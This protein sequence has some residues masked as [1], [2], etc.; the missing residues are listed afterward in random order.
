MF[1]LFPSWRLV[2]EYRNMDNSANPVDITQLQ[3]CWNEIK[4]RGVCNLFGLHWDEIEIR[5]GVKL[6]KRTGQLIGFKDFTI[7][8]ELE[9]DTKFDE[10]SLVEDDSNFP[11]EDENDNTSDDDSEKYASDTD[12][13]SDGN[14]TG[15]RK[16]KVA[17]QIC[18][19]FLTSLEGNFTWPVGSFPVYSV[20]AEKLNKH[21][22]WPLVKA[23]DKVSD[24]K[25]KVVYG[26][27]DGGP[28]NSIFFKKSSKK[29]SMGWSE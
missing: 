7:P 3:N 2:Q 26:V 27:C 10:I 8:S 15:N 1:A 5:S 18:Q 16:T 25:I 14:S 21:M 20:T 17:R 23:L 28:W 9:I 4:Q 24:G 19:F 13:D 12:S 22:V 11:E 29:I 6:C